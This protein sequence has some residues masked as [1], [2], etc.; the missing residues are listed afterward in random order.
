MVLEGVL[1]GTGTADASAAE[2]GKLASTQKQR[3][4]ME[5]ENLTPSSTLR[6][7]FG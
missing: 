4:E 3:L 1:E 6:W 2:T 5:L 7:I